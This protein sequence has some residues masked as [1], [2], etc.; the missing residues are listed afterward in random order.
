MES[1]NRSSGAKVRV[2]HRENSACGGRTGLR[3][4]IVGALIALAFG[5]IAAT[6]QGSDRV[7]V[8]AGGGQHLTGGGGGCLGPRV[9]ANEALLGAGGRV[10]RSVGAANLHV[11]GS[12]LGTPWSEVTYTE[13]SDDP[14]VA[15]EEVRELEREDYSSTYRVALN[16]R[17]GR[18]FEHGGYELGLSVM[19]ADAGAIGESTIGWDRRS[20]TNRHSGYVLPAGAFWVGRSEGVYGF[21][22]L[23]A[24]TLANGM[25]YAISYGFSTGVGWRNDWGDVAL[26]ADL[27][28]HGW[29]GHARVSIAVTERMSFGGTFTGGTGLRYDSVADM[30]YLGGSL[31]LSFA[32]Q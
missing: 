8:I 5:S 6:P 13:L 27:G 26:A 23:G 19:A 4:T 7:E 2:R 9:D 17:A 30:R 12:V 21:G 28:L 11:D 20:A 31:H 3:L 22:E 10:D 24:P 29:G 1:K 16:V 15:A 25:S 14:E 32:L 18:H